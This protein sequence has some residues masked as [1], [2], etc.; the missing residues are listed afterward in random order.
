MPSPSHNLFKRLKND[1]RK[2]AR[3]LEVGAMFG[4]SLMAAPGPI[5]IGLEPYRPYIAR[6]MEKYDPH[7]LFVLGSDSDICMFHGSYLDAII[8]IDMIE[9]LSKER[10]EILLYRCQKMVSRAVIVFTPNGFH[11]QDT[12]STG[13]GA[14]G[15][16]TH[17]CGWTKT[18]L[19][20]FGFHTEIWPGYHRKEHPDAP[21]ALYAVYLK[22]E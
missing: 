20:A 8:L 12:D 5:R 16:Q 1:L 6:G 10:G 7:I 11:H 18:E 21:D 2:C 13:M 4:D 17:Q 15:L 19:D 9:H 14:H 3:V 22:K